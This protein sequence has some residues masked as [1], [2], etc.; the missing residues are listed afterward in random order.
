MAA[1]TVN[2]LSYNPTGLNNVFKQKWTNDLLETFKADFVSIQEHFKKNVG[3]FFENKFPDYF[4]FIVPAAR[5]DNQDSGRPKGGLA[6][7]QSSRLQLKT[8]RISSPNTRLQ[9]QILEFPNISLLWIN[10][11]FPTD[12]QTMNLENDELQHLLRDIRNIIE[13]EEFDHVMISGD[14]NWDPKRNTGFSNEIREFLAN[15]GLVSVW[16]KFPVSH[17]HIHTDLSSLSTL[18]YFIMNPALLEAVEQAEAIH[19]G[20]NLSRHNY[21]SKD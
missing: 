1:P 5:A 15:M 10:T 6:Q 2:F 16:D 8:K 14:I 19:L 3:S 12:P 11:Y 13:N 18:D 20:D 21:Q 9:A 17:T 4:S 7:L